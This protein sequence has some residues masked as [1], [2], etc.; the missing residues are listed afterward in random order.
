MKQ[1]IQLD[2]NGYFTG[3]TVA[4]LSPLEAGVYLMP[5]G[6]VDAEAPT[7]TDSQCAK[8]DGSAWSVEDIPVEEPAPEP[9]P[10]DPAVE[11]RVKRDG[12]LASSDWTQ[13]ADAPVNKAA[14]ASYR[15]LLRFVPQQAAFPTDITWP[16]KPT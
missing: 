11:A 13:V 10:L 14:W 15:S 4:D 12:L 16:T 7:I 8:W 2:D 6:T 1:V 9:E 3:L 5:A